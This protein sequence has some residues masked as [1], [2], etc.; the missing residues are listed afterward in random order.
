[1]LPI[2]QP[3]P[4]SI[5]NPK[6]N[7]MSTNRQQAVSSA[8]RSWKVKERLAGWHRSIAC[9]S[10]TSPS[11]SA[12]IFSSA[13]P[14]SYK[15]WYKLRRCMQCTEYIVHRSSFFCQ[16]DRKCLSTPL[17]AMP[18]TEYGS[19]WLETQLWNL[20][21]II[22]KFGQNCEILQIMWIVVTILIFGWDCVMLLTLWNWIEILQFG[23]LEWFIMVWYGSLWFGMAR[24]G[25]V[26]SRLLW[27]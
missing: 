22:V 14:F 12:P 4:F 5:S 18:V 2:L 17:W 16:H 27:I 8:A 15:V 26:R 13:P 11:D 6:H 25:L 7:C 24:Y 1:M 9:N 3:Q 20:F 19:T 23:W 21:E 10:F